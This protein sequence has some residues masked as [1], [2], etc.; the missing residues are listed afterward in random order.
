MPGCGRQRSR[1]GRGDCEMRAESRSYLEATGVLNIG[2]KRAD[3]DSVDHNEFLVMMSVLI[4]GFTFDDECC[5]NSVLAWGAEVV[6]KMRE[7]QNR[8]YCMG[9]HATLLLPSSQWA[10]AYGVW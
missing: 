5:D 10:K 2:S 8:R 6:G 7:E 4:A 1:S 3:S 9:S